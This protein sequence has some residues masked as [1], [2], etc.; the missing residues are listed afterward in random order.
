[1]IADHA[2]PAVAIKFSGRKMN[3]KSLHSII[4]AFLTAAIITGCGS[5]ADNFFSGRPS[6]MSLVHNRVIAGGPEAM[7]TLLK[8][9]VQFPEANEA[10]IGM[11]QSSIIAWWRNANRKEEIE[12]LFSE[13]SR[14]EAYHLLLW[15]KVRTKHETTENSKTLTEI[16]IALSLVHKF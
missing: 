7:A 3:I 13:I 11:W 1:M 2:L 10:Q 5:D 4:L 15:V 12:S 16:E 8:V 9:P 6:E 14:N